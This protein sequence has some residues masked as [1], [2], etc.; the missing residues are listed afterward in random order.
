MRVCNTENKF[1][2]KRPGLS[3][4][5]FYFPVHSFDYRRSIDSSVSELGDS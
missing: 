3:A 5:T 4:D 2:G 1:V